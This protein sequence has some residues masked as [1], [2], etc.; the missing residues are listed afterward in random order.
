MRDGIITL[1]CGSL[2]GAGLAI[3]GMADPARVRS[4]LDVFGAWDPTL[5]FVMAGA[6]I[7][8]VFAWRIRSILDNPLAAETFYLPDTER[9]DLR[10][11]A[12]AAI[13]GIGWGVAGLCPGPAV[14]GIALR[15][16]DASIF[17][18]AMIV[19]IAVHR[20]FSRAGGRIQTQP[21]EQG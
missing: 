12:G 18:I 10:L 15:P 9:L 5:V 14:A 2:F 21:M 8:M 4:F 13:F 19:G 1:V 6:I 7:P 17:V 11:L 16:S 3:S 20:G